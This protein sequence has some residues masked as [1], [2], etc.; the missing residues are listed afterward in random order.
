MG[1]WTAA[2]Q[3]LEKWEDNEEEKEIWLWRDDM[4]RR[5]KSDSLSY[6]FLEN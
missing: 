2:G 3:V 6:C 4:R 5:S 1:D